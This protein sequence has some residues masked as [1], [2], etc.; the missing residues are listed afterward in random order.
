MSVESGDGFGK[1]RQISDNFPA[2]VA[3]AHCHNPLNP[4]QG[5]YP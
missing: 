5:T 3:D 4:G 1:I 2:V